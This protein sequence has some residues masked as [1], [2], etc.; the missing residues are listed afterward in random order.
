V[1]GAIALPPRPAHAMIA[2]QPM[3]EV[4]HGASADLRRCR[5]THEM[6]DGHYVVRLEVDVLG[7]VVRF[8]LDDAPAAL[9]TPSVSCVQAAFSRLRFPARASAAPDVRRHQARAPG[10]HLPPDARRVSGGGRILVSW[11]FV[12]APPR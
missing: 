11:P 6:P 12:F 9:P 1:F 8:W 4:L 10:T 3:R 7:K 5:A 2:V